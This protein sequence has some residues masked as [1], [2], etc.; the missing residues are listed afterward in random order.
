M[1]A[2][3]LAVIKAT[4]LEE[5]SISSPMSLQGR[6]QFSLLLYV[7]VQP[8]RNSVRISQAIIKSR[9]CFCCT[10][11]VRSSLVAGWRYSCLNACQPAH[12]W[13]WTPLVPGIQ[14]LLSAWMNL[15]IASLHTELISGMDF[16]VWQ[17]DLH[18][19][20]LASFLECDDS[21]CRYL[22]L[23]FA[24]FLILIQRHVYQWR[25]D[26]VVS[27]SPPEL[28]DLCWKICKHHLPAL[29]RRQSR[30]GSHTMLCSAGSSPI[31]HTFLCVCVLTS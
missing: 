11:E 4:T 15:Y 28:G 17:L 2:Q 7:F 13:G 10:T 25:N 16:A 5:F 1:H 24:A 19:F 29:M 20:N 9:L 12:W 8:E 27:S 14:C 26:A 30:T 31:H 6:W 23:G 18:L 3:P 21:L 22:T